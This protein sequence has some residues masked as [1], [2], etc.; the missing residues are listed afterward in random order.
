MPLLGF[1]HDPF[2]EG[3]TCQYTQLQFRGSVRSPILKPDPHTDNA[4]QLNSTQFQL[5]LHLQL[6][7]VAVRRCGF[8][9]YLRLCLA[10]LPRPPMT[11][12]WAPGA[13]KNHRSNTWLDA[14]S[15]FLTET[16]RERERERARQKG[17]RER[18]RKRECKKEKERG[19]TERGRNAKINTQN[20]I[21]TPEGN[22]WAKGEDAQQPTP[23]S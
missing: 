21:F 6:I 8:G 18:E 9:R 16:E 22:I 23:R 7:L 20:Q 4:T 5:Q 3:I 13:L 12:L 19:A 14:T 10:T 15:W 1:L 2:Y 17:E 11:E